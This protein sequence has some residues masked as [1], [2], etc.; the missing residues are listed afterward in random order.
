MT[1]NDDDDEKA[2][3]L[4]AHECLMEG[5]GYLGKVYRMQVERVRQLREELKRLKDDK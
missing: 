2:R 5:G 4:K 1:T 3:L